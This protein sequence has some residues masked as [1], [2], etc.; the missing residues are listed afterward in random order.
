AL[1]IG[2][3]GPGGG[4]RLIRPPAE[5]SLKDVAE[6]FERETEGLCPYG[7]GW[8]GNQTPCPLHNSISAMN[9]IIEDFL[10]NTNFATFQNSKPSPRKR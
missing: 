2:S 10:K 9:Q 3:P 6:L 1:V 4:Y 5:I 7:P 8:C